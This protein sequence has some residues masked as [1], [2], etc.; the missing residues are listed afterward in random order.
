MYVFISRNKKQN[1]VRSELQF[2]LK[3]IFASLVRN[4]IYLAWLAITHP[5]SLQN[6]PNRFDTPRIPYRKPRYTP[7]RRWTRL[8]FLAGWELFRRRAE[9]GRAKTFR[10]FGPCP[11]R[12]PTLASWSDEKFPLPQISAPRRIHSGYRSPTIRQV[13]DMAKTEIRAIRQVIDMAK[14]EIRQANRI[15]SIVNS[16]LC[17]SDF[18]R[19]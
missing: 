2:S 7:K 10:A 15:V 14:I 3:L 11:S 18:S 12:C 5:L 8:T 9:G 16:I 1:Q 6:Y 4:I 13:I 19:L 17:L